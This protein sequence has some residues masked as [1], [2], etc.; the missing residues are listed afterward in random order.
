MGEA[1]TNSTERAQRYVEALLRSVSYCTGD[2]LPPVRVMAARAHVA[3][4]AVCSALKKCEARKLLVVVKGYGVVVGPGPVIDS[5]PAKRTRKWERIRMALESDMA[6]EVFA[7]D[8]LP[9]IR[10]LC[11]RYGVSFTVMRHAIAVL[12][13]ER[14]I[15]HQHKGFIVRRAVASRHYSEVAYLFPGFPQNRRV[16]LNDRFIETHRTLE[17]ECARSGIRYDSIAIGADARPDTTVRLRDWSRYI[18]FVV[19]TNGLTVTPGLLDLLL[20]ELV[21]QRKPLAIIDEIGNFTPP[22]S[23]RKSPAFRIFTIASVSA[24]KTIGRFLHGLGHRSIV[25]ISPFHDSEWSRQRLRGLS[26]A[27]GTCRDTQIIS[28]TGSPPPSPLGDYRALI[29]QSIYDLREVYRRIGLAQIPED[30]GNIRL[31]YE[32]AV[33]LAQRKMYSN[34]YRNVFDR[35]I[36]KAPESAWVAVNDTI[37]EILIRYCR[38]KSI[39]VPR[40]CS[41]AGFDNSATAFTFDLTS[42]DFNFSGLARMAFWHIINPSSPL[43]KN[44]SQRIECEGFVVERRSTCMAERQS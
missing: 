39:P 7:D 33:G 35:T 26:E 8:T 23:C 40:S 6:S 29:S 44:P 9:P 41:I 4:A 36:K 27:F 22:P 10:E 20:N 11:N 42:Y 25:Y 43:F 31:I 16:A 38:E 15:I 2:L 24:G 13:N 5:T 32:I 21:Q 3:P 18:G 12:L 30:D 17:K 34:F 28:F 1:H 37:A 14:V 19:W